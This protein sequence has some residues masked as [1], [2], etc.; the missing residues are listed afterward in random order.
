MQGFGKN[1]E[2]KINVFMFDYIIYFFMVINLTKHMLHKY[3]IPLCLITNHP[4]RQSTNS[5]QT[6]TV[7][8][9]Q[10]NIYI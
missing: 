5:H 1:K 2:Y 8:L 3:F 4:N 9:H 6:I 10:Y 7:E